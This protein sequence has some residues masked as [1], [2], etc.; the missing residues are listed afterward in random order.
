MI[1]IIQISSTAN[2]GVYALT[3]SGRIFRG[4][5]KESVPTHLKKAGGYIQGMHKAVISFEW[6]EIPKIPE[7]FSFD[8]EKGGIE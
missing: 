3:S 2:G 1:K 5:W 8:G 7:V 4:I 6:E